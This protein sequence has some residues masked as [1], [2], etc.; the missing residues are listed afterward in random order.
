MLV[1]EVDGGD[2][3]EAS[4]P[5]QEA[6]LQKAASEALQR[7][8]QYH[9]SAVAHRAAT[10]SVE[11]WRWQAVLKQATS[12]VTSKREPKAR[13]AFA[14]YQIERGDGGGSTKLAPRSWQWHET[15]RPPRLELNTWAWTMLEKAPTG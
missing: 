14:A 13:A 10:A 5:T 12:M 4:R 11:G 3:R 9:L 2:Q 1:E 15:A 7:P 8:R 6:K